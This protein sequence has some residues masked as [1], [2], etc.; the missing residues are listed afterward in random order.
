ML[1]LTKCKE[2]SW[3]FL[4]CVWPLQVTLYLQF[5]RRIFHINDSELQT[6]DLLFG[7]IDIAI[8]DHFI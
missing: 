5:S 6:R 8:N 3:L 7:L 4:G 1:G 2:R